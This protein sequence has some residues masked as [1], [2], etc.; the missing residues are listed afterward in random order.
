MAPAG[1]CSQPWTGRP[2]KPG[3]VTSYV[4][5]WVS[6]VS[7]GANT[8]FGTGPPAAG[9]SLRVLDQKASKLSG[10]GSSGR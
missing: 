1:R 8:G 9:A 5:N 3:N 7:T 6:P 10:T 4:W 2:A